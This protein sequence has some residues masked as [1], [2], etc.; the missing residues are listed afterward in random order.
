MLP[1]TRTALALA[2][3]TLAV[4]D[5]GIQ[6]GNGHTADFQL[7]KINCWLG[8]G[9]LVGPASSHLACHP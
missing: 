4:Y 7:A 9:A 2:K 8:R 5:K 1:Q 6:Q 3:G